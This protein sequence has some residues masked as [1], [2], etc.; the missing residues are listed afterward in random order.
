MHALRANT[1]RADDF[2]KIMRM[3]KNR[4]KETDIWTDRHI[5]L[6]G[7]QCRDKCMLMLDPTLEIITNTKIEKFPQTI[8]QTDRYIILPRR[9]FDPMAYSCMRWM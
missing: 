1:G 8:G 4:Y 7:P 9:G 5:I 2:Q 6:T 3:T